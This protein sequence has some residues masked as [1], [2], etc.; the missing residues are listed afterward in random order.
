[1]PKAYE[2]MRDKFAQSMPLKA[3]KTKAAKIYNSNNPGN[4]VT[5]KSEGKRKRGPN[6]HSLAGLQRSR[7]PGY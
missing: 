2:S 5:G 4:P 1:M 6:K 3:A 7:R